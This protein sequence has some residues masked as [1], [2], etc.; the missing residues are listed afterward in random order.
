MKTYTIKLNEQELD[1]LISC[2]GFAKDY[3]N[4]IWKKAFKPA[5]QFYAAIKKLETKLWK[6]IKK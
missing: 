5:P 2:L 1:D 3:Y 4:Q 6:V